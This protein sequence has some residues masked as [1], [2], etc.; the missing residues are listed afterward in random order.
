ML[1]RSD[2][3]GPVARRTSHLPGGSMNLQL[4][5]RFVSSSALRTRALQI[6]TSLTFLAI[7]G[8]LTNPAARAQTS[9]SITGI[10]TD[11]PGAVIQGAIVN[12]KNIE[13]GAIRDTATNGAGRYFV[14]DL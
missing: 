7:I 6:L 12:V 11:P 5:S 14:L 8:F 3:G 2:R 1:A 9:G 10:I 13:T 4:P